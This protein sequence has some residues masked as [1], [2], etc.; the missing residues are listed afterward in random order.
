[1]NFFFKTWIGRI[2]TVFA[3]TIILTISGRIID[4]AYF[5]NPIGEG[6]VGV[7][8]EDK[9]D[10]PATTEIE[11]MVDGQDPLRID[12]AARTTDVSGTIEVLAPDGSMAYSGRVALRYY[13]NT[14]MPNHAR[15]QTFLVPARAK[16]QYKVRL[17][18]EQFGEVRAL[19]YQ[20]PFVMRLLVSVPLVAVFLVLVVSVT[21]SKKPEPELLEEPQNEAVS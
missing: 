13:P 2:M 4:P 7:K 5:E 6:V 14:F 8:T 3:L 20:G 10:L 17:T 11:V 21:I 9:Y 12:L 19:F 15:W 1:M 16:G 18:Q